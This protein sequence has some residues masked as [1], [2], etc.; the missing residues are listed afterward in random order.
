MTDATSIGI[1]PTAIVDP[2][3]EIDAG[4]TIGPYCV[5][6]A[7]VCIGKNCWLG[8]HVHIAPGVRIGAGCRV[9][10]GAVLGSIPQDLKFEGEETM[11]EI[12]ERTTIREFA[13]L[14]RGTKDH[15]K[16]TIGSDCLLM[17]YSHVAH[18]CSI[19]DHCILANS[20]NLAGHVVI[21]GWASIGGMVP[22]HQFVRI[23]QHSFVGGGYRVVKDVPPYILAVGD[24]MAFGGLN[25]VGLSRRGFPEATLTVLKR[26]YRL[27]YKSRLNVSQAVQRIREEC[28]LI[29][30]VQNILA[31][32]EKS[33]RGIIR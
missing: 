28:E 30:E 3:A 26:A 27:L 9:F 16:T 29:P 1:H 13:T 24:P 23:G 8:P 17:A 21:E 25:S 12:G 10:T 18:D 32:I 5:I 14:N 4:V 2:K 7:N 31:F 15:W 6:E 19:G 33:E 11:L 22:V 20:V